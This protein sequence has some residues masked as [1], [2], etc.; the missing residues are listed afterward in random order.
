MMMMRV[1]VVGVNNKSNKDSEDNEGN[2]SN[3]SNKSNN[4]NPLKI[5]NKEE[6]MA[7]VVRET[8][9]HGQGGRQ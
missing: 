5:N 7:M 4:N 8:G 9:R 3:K 1:M 6:G 2:K